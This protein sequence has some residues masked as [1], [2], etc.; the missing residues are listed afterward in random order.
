MGSTRCV[1][2]LSLFVGFGFASFG[3]NNASAQAEA[4]A[5]IQLD[6]LPTHWIAERP[7]GRGAGPVTPAMLE[8]P[9]AEGSAWG[10]SLVERMR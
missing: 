3:A 10:G 4:P 8:E 6:P 9:F 2:A 7:V 5:E 1:L